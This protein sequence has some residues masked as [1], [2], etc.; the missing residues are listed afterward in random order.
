M[1]C[2]FTGS[3]TSSTAALDPRVSTTLV[4][5][6]LMRLTAV[7]DSGCFGLVGVDFVLSIVELLSAIATHSPMTWTVF[8]SNGSRTDETTIPLGSGADLCLVVLTMNLGVRLGDRPT[9]TRQRF[10][11]LYVFRVARFVARS[12]HRD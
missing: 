12:R 8:S 4:G 3:H 11:S 10:R 6:R 5:L 7:F 2:Y 1:I 9:G